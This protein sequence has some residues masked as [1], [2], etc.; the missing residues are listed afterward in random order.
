MGVSPNAFFMVL[1]FVKRIKSISNASSSSSVKPKRQRHKSSSLSEGENKECSNLLPP[2]AV[3][4]STSA[5]KNKNITNGERRENK[6]HSKRQLFNT[7][8]EEF[9]F[10]AP[11]WLNFKFDKAALMECIP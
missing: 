4:S 2:G 3:A 9:V 1:P 10:S 5:S 6:R 7:N 11:S 8:Q